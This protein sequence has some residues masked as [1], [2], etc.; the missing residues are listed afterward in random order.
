MEHHLCIAACTE[1]AASGS[2][3]R[4]GL[5]SFHLRGVGSFVS[6][7]VCST[8]PACTV[9]HCAPTAASLQRQ[10]SAFRPRKTGLSCRAEQSAGQRHATTGQGVEGLGATA[11][12]QE[13]EV[14]VMVVQPDEGVT[15]A[16]KLAASPKQP[17]QQV[18]AQ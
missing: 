13:P 1:F 14:T 9:Q 18:F 16:R 11:T 4:L 7:E 8:A 15:I 5:L 17:E 6:V 3:C 10:S 2:A 12:E